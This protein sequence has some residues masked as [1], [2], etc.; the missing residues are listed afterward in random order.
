MNILVIANLSK[1]KAHELTK[2]VRDYLTKH[3]AKVFGTKEQATE[4]RLQ[5]YEEGVSID[6]IIS[7]GGDGSILKVVHE[8]PKLLAPI[9]GINLG[10]LGF[11]ADIPIP[12]TFDALDQI[13]RGAYSVQ[14]R[15]MLEGHTKN[16]VC[17]AARG[18]FLSGFVRDIK[19]FVI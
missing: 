19:I 5:L 17:F 12:K 9:M 7:L 3:N 1:P 4:F 8:Y 10:S 16:Q 13:L 15:L 18:F 14:E 2:S 11:L 6:L